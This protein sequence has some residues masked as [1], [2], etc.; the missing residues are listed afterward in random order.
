MNEIIAFAA[1]AAFFLMISLMSFLL[2]R[3]RQCQVVNTHLLKEKEALQTQNGQLQEE[4]KHLKS[5]ERLILTKPFVINMTP[6]MS[7]DL[8]ANLGPYLQQAVNKHL[9]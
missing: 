2:G 8:A 9:N 7:Q 3:V 1:G 6:E 4:N 5:R